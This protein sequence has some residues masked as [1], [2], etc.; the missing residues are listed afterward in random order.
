M[1]QN[2]KIRNK[3]LHTKLTLNTF[4]KIKNRNHLKESGAIFLFFSVNTNQYF[5][6]H[7]KNTKKIL[8]TRYLFG[9]FNPAFSH[10]VTSIAVKLNINGS[11]PCYK[12]SL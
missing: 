7:S 1:R 8:P 3:K 4:F 10:S 9:V 11:L 2:Q 12:Y 6:I 5:R